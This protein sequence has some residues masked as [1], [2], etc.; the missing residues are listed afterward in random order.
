MT[1]FI[2]RQSA[3]HHWVFEL[4]EGRPKDLLEAAMDLLDLNVP[5]PDKMSLVIDHSMYVFHTKN[6]RQQFGLGMMAGLDGSRVLLED[7][8]H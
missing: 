1:L 6:E 4:G 2:I 8:A 7:I 5:W 3:P